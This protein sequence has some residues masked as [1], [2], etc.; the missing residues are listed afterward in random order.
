MATN[1]EAVVWNEENQV[2]W[3]GIRPGYYGDQVTGYHAIVNGTVDIYEVPANKILLLFTSWTTA[4]GPV[5]GG[6]HAVML[7]RNAVPAIVHEIHRV[8]I[9]GVTAVV[10][11]QVSRF[12]PLVCPTEYF[13]SLQSTIA[14]CSAKGGFEG[15]LIDA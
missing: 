6:G 13:I 8:P 5:V 15:I 12:S 4:A 1:T 2:K 7:L 14:G 9:G 11:Q 10:S 3:Q